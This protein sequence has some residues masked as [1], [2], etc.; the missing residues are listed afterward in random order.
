MAE[1]R[2]SKGG[3]R[4]VKVSGDS[5]VDFTLYQALVNY[6]AGTNLITASELLENLA[7]VP[8]TEEEFNTAF[9]E[10]LTVISEQKI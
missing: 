1:F 3:R 4:H 2:R 9:K 7:L 5:F 8:C 6:S 10:A